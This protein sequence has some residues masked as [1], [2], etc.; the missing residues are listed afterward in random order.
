MM[1]VMSVAEGY[2]NSAGAGEFSPQPDFRPVTK[3]QNRGEKLGHGV[4]DLIF[5]RIS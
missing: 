4:W 5:E 2:R 1:E 3:F